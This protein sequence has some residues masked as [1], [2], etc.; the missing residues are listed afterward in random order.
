MIERGHPAQKRLTHPLFVGLE[1]VHGAR[2]MVAAAAA[3]DAVATAWVG[4]SGNRREGHERGTVVRF[5]TF[6]KHDHE[7]GRAKARYV[8]LRAP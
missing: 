4:G 2:R 7:P 5:A 3:R 8:L 1:Q 6:V